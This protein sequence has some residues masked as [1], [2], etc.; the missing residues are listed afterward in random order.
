MA[1]FNPACSYSL[2]RL[3]PA[4]VTTSLTLITQI[5][6]VTADQI[7]PANNPTPALSEFVF[8]NGNRI[9]GSLSHV[10]PEIQTITLESPLS[11][12]PLTIDVNHLHRIYTGFIKTPHDLKSPAAVHLINNDVLFG[13]V[14][15]ITDS[16]V[17]INNPAFDNLNIPLNQIQNINYETSTTLLEGF[18]EAENWISKSW[19][20][21]DNSV[22]SPNPVEIIDNQAV[23][24]S[25]ATILR[26]LPEADKIHISFNYFFGSINPELT[27]IFFSSDTE[28]HNQSSN[29]CSVQINKNS[30]SATR[31]N[32]DL[33][34]IQRG[35]SS[36]RLGNTN[37]ILPSLAQEVKI[38]IFADRSEGLIKL[39]VNNE[40]VASWIDE[41]KM[42]GDG[43]AFGFLT[44]AFLRFNTY[45]KRNNIKLPP[46]QTP[47]T[48]TISNL[49]VKR[50]HNYPD[51]NRYDI[52]DD[53]VHPHHISMLNGD[54][55]RGTIT[56]ITDSKSIIST[57]SFGDLPLPNEHISRIEQTTISIPAEPTP[58]NK[59][60]IRVTLR[61]GSTFTLL[62]SSINTQN[63]EGTSLQLG[64]ISIPFEAAF[65][66]EFNL[67]SDKD[68]N[69]DS[70]LPPDPNLLLDHHTE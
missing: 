38:D 70:P 10:D 13:K 64:K 45:T 66:L 67:H 4:T 63:I 14:S 21:P 37:F 58:D 52:M 69:V 26:N 31:N 68:E 33:A 40:F 65:A 44:H 12:S 15:S 1:I 9:A 28:H 6:S 60:T 50:W 7:E 20:D 27:I 62:P 30:A 51:P 57:E 34:H 56:E 49:H 11:I 23:F 55:F 3:L 22:N 29:Y 16:S 24:Q 8:T 5:F 53:S 59:N 61:D 19:P 25:D 46:T 42:F 18:K 2:V 35:R 36:E 32:P 47:T 17:T 43:N 48:Q 39:F 54:H 41:T